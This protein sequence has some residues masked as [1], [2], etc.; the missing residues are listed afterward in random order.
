MIVRVNERCPGPWL[1]SWR[2]FGS[3][4]IFMES[5]SGGG[6]GSGSGSGGSGSGSGSSGSSS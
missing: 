1:R 5:S 2:R 4:S 3:S 6:N